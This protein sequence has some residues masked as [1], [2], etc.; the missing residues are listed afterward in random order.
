MMHLV[1]SVIVYKEWLFYGRDSDIIHSL[2]Y[3]VAFRWRRVFVFV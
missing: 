1:V 2:F 3:F